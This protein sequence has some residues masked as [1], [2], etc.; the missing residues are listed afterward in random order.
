MR[1]LVQLILGWNIGG[2][3]LFYFRVEH[4]D[5]NQWRNQKHMSIMMDDR[6]DW[7]EF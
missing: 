2:I 1:Q 6:L 4:L 7:W 3:F 5:E